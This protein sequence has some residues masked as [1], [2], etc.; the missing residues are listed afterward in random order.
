MPRWSQRHVRFRE[1]RRVLSPGGAFFFTFLPYWLSWTQRLS[2]LR[3][4]RY[5]DRLYRTAYVRRLA[6]AAGLAVE[7]VWHGQLF[8]K[9]S[10]PHRTLVERVDRF[11]TGHTPLRYLTGHTP[12]MIGDSPGTAHGLAQPLTRL[13]PI[14]VTFRLLP[15]R[16]LLPLLPPYFGE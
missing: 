15:T 9:N 2:H 5:H 13:Y 7:G 3:G 4:Y 10:Q 16:T 6:A 1:I 8:P 11:L 12:L 14:H